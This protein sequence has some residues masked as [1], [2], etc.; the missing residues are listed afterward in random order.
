MTHTPAEIILLSMRIDLTR[1]QRVVSL[2]GLSLENWL[3]AVSYASNQE[4]LALM[5]ESWHNLACE[6]GIPHQAVHAAKAMLLRNRVRTARML[7]GLGQILSEMN[8][9]AMPVIV[10]K[11]AHLATMYYDDIGKRPMS[12]LDL[13]IKPDHLAEAT[14]ILQRLGYQPDPSNEAQAEIGKHFHFKHPENEIK[15]ELHWQVLAQ[16]HFRQSP[17][18]LIWYSAIP[19]MISGEPALGLPAEGLLPYFALHLYNHRFVVPLRQVWDTV[20]VLQKEAIDW[21]LILERA[22]EWQIERSLAVLLHLSA[23]LWGLKFPAAVSAFLDEF[24]LDEWGTIAR[25]NIMDYQAS[26]Y[27]MTSPRFLKVWS[28]NSR[29]MSKVKLLLEGLF[30]S[31]EW[32]SMRYRVAGHGAPLFAAYLRRLIEL[33]FDYGKVGWKLLR[34]QHGEWRR[35]NRQKAFLDWLDED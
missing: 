32:V 13:L 30:P 19:I 3:Q 31:R 18:D 4:V 21:K 11:G 15:I 10:L 35:L 6:A 5:S 26:D 25:K 7:K 1:D 20:V 34:G 29:G 9:A 28:H 22:R 8:N 27:A 16:E 23:E 24:D 33:P 17:T 14:G 12:D 2:S